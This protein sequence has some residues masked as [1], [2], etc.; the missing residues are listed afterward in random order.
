MGNLLATYTK[1]QLRQTAV[2]LADETLLIPLLH[3]LPQRVDQVNITMGVS[4]QTMPYATFFEILFA[5]K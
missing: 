5:V 2:V 1:E 3:S 4:L